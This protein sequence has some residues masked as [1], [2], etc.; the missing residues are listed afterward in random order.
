MSGSVASR[1]GA[2]PLQSSAVQD[3][4]R[5]G[6]GSDG[7]DVIA[8]WASPADATVHFASRLAVETDV[9]DV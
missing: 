5:H 4:V 7:R 9:S 8:D 2:D 3:L 6:A 1:G